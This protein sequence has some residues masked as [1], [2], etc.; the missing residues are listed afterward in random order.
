[1]NSPDDILL[2]HKAFANLADLG[3]LIADPLDCPVRD[4]LARITNFTNIR[5]IQIVIIHGRGT[6]SDEFSGE[7][8]EGVI[9]TCKGVNIGM[10]DR[11]KWGT[12]CRGGDGRF[13]DLV[14]NGIGA[15]SSLLIL[16]RKVDDESRVLRSQ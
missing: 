2:N 1:M 4:C 9:F 10:L 7:D 13:R 11:W 5:V 6:T 16:G 15:V 14:P 3:A 12:G 8:F